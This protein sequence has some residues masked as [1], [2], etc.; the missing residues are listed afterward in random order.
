MCLNDRGVGLG[1]SNEFKRGFLVLTGEWIV[2]TCVSS[3]LSCVHGTGARRHGACSP[4]I[5]S[6]CGLSVSCQENKLRYTV[7][8]VSGPVRIQEQ[9]RT[10]EKT[11]AQAERGAGKAKD[12][13][14][15]SPRARFFLP[16]CTP[17]LSR[18]GSPS[19]MNLRSC[20]RRTLRSFFA[21]PATRPPT[22]PKSVS[23][24]TSLKAQA[25][26]KSCDVCL[27]RRRCHLATSGL[28]AQQPA[29]CCRSR[30]ESTLRSAHSAFTSLGLSPTRE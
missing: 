10:C 21:G 24:R 13:A 7:W 4:D 2:R 20:T 12:H 1:T 11:A 15:S 29:T 22:N 23:I 30:T 9:N 3:Y 25:I 27:L 28:S 8:G 16:L 5:L 14:R 18:Q 6:T 26:C 17:R 19:R